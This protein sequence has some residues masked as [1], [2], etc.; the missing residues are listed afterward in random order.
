M[1]QLQSLLP[2]DL[3]SKRIQGHV[4]SSNVFKCLLDIDLFSIRIQGGVLSYVPVKDVRRIGKVL[5][6]VKMITVAN[7]SRILVKYLDLDS[8]FKM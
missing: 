5:T 3:F 8:R 1:F 6:W 2:S 4:L 7:A